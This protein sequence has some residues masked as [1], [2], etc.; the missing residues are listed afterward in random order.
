MNSIGKG[1][2]GR[3]ELNTVYPGRLIK[4]MAEVG[5]FKYS[6][7]YFLL[8]SGLAMKLRPRIPV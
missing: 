4:D 8:L 1:G 6:K 2:K 3:C 7:Q 5:Y